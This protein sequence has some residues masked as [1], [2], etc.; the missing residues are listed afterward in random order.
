MRETPPHAAW[1]GE[2]ATWTGLDW[3]PP[4][5]DEDDDPTPRRHPGAATGRGAGLASGGGAYRSTG[6]ARTNWQRHRA[7]RP[8]AAP[9]TA[10]RDRSPMGP[11]VPAAFLP[12]PPRP[13]PP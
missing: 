11:F 1:R 9:W 12:R 3:T 10:D 13:G 6:P 7:R 2:H 8:A 5:I 4:G